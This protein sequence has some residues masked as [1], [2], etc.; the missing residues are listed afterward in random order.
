M[1]RGREEKCIQGFDVIKWR[2]IKTSREYGIYVRIREMHDGFL[3]EKL[4]KRTAQEV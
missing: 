2:R 4:R 1:T 3:W